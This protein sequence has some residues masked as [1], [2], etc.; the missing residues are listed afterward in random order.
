MAST[1]PTSSPAS[2]ST[3]TTRSTRPPSASEPGGW[4]STS[5]RTWR[6]SH[7][8]PCSRTSASSGRIGF[9]ADFVGV[10]ADLGMSALRGRAGH[11]ALRESEERYRQ[12]F[13]AESDAVFLIDNETGSILEANSAASAMYGYSRDEL[14]A[15]T[16]EDLSAEPEK[17]QAV[18]LGTPVVADRVITIS[19]AHPSQEGR[20]H[21]PRGDHRPLLHASGA[22]PCTWRPSVTSQGA[23]R[24]RR[25]C[26]CS[27]RQVLHGVSQQ[28]RRDPHHQGQRRAGHGC[29]RWF[30]QAV[31]VHYQGRSSRQVP[32]SRSIC[33]YRSARPRNA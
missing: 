29:Q 8:C 23:S 30:R 13:E 1:S 7:A 4:V 14:L 20:L 31:G 3:T 5:R 32:P 24:Q 6:R 33:G 22:G 27:Q 28:P 11:E 25:P 21:L 10:L 15:R 12:L 16:N 18:T 19:A 26:A 2:S 17:T 9:V